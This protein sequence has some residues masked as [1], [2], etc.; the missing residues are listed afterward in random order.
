MSR[1]ASRLLGFLELLQ[2]CSGLACA[3][4]A[5]ELGVSERT[6]RRYAVA[7]QDLGIQVEGQSGLGG[8]YRLRPGTQLPPLML[9]DEEAVAAVYGLVLADERGLSGARKALDKVSRVLPEAIGTRIDRLRSE[10]VLSG[11][12]TAPAVSGEILLRVAEAVR[13]RRSLVIDYVRGDGTE[14]GGRQIEPL[15]LV[16]RQGRWYV[17]A[18]DRA[19]G[20][21]RTFRADR[22]RA[23]SLGD[24]AAPP[25]HGFD[26]LTYVV[27]MLKRLP[28]AWEIEV[29]VHGSPAEIETRIPSTMV[30]LRPRGD[31]TQ[32]LLKTDSLQYA[33]TLLVGLDMD[34]DVARPPALREELGR[35][36]ARLAAAASAQTS[37]P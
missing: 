16:A 14:S 3:T 28:R 35:L 2:N 34:F 33:S 7:L 22:I 10:V 31:R 17:P 27:D 36:S 19:R 1:P 6:I 18:R 20:E 30:E 5:H 12:P 25:D 23:A 32:L 24:G 37:D 9:S 13:R 21:L 4:A 11:E 29:L 8:G 26:P 15:G